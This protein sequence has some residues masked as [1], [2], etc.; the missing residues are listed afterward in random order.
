MSSFEASSMA[1]GQLNL[2][3]LPGRFSLAKKN[4][5]HGFEEYLDDNLAKQTPQDEILKTNSLLKNSMNSQ[6]S[7]EEPS[8]EDRAV[9]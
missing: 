7:S 1:S 8:I 2:Q 5:E 3:V 9:Y 6:G 4:S